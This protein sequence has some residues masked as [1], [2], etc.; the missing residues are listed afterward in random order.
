MDV[1]EDS[2]GDD[3]SLFYA[4]T[5]KLATTESDRHRGDN[6]TYTLRIPTY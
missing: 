6:A 3:D 2:F 5:P 4:R 1:D